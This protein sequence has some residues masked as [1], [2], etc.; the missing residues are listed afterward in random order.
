MKTTGQKFGFF[1]IFTILALVLWTFLLNVMAEALGWG[2]MGVA[3]IW[4]GGLADILVWGI[5]LNIISANIWKKRELQYPENTFD[6]VFTNVYLAC[7]WPIM[8]LTIIIMFVCPISLSVLVLTYGKG[9]FGNIF[10]GPHFT[11]PLY[12]L[13]L[14]LVGL[15]AVIPAIIA[16]S[17]RNKENL[18]GEQPDDKN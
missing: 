2:G 3:A 8:T 9:V 11:S 7:I 6:Q 17:T 15:L 1:F 13:I 16:A 4:F 5:I 18:Q 14:P 12:L 10:G